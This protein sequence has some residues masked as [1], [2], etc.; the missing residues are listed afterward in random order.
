MFENPRTGRQARNFTTN[1]PKI[2]VLKSSSEQIFSRKLPLGAPVSSLFVHG[3][4]TFLLLTPFGDDAHLK[5]FAYKTNS[6]LVGFSN[7]RTINCK[8][9]I[10]REIPLYQSIYSEFK[11]W[12]LV[13]MSSYEWWWSTYSSLKMLLLY[14]ICCLYVLC[15]RLTNACRAALRSFW[16]ISNWAYNS[17]TL[18]KVNCKKRRKL[19]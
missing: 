2:L 6:S 16:R 4:N 19:C 13:A 8:A 7:N 15:V 11:V 1:V 9:R 17:H 12:F 18:P 5:C 3:A 10:M 14:L